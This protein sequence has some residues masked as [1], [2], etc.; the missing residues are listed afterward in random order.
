MVSRAP[1]YAQPV[2]SEARFWT[3]RMRWR[4]R[5]AWQWPAFALLTLADGI[6]LH[7]LPPIRTGVDLIPAWIIASFGNLLLVGL[8]APWIA[9]RLVSRARDQSTSDVSA[10]PEVIHDRTGTAILVAG[11]LALIVTGLATRPL[12]VSETEAT[13]RLAAS[14][15]DYVLAH[16]STE[17]RRNLDTA[18]TTQTDEQGYFRTCIALDDRTRAFCLFVDT[19][20]DP[21][22]IVEDQDQRPNQVYF[23]DP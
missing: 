5:G 17:V 20:E 12:V 9:R 18:N 1:G 14:V 22:T 21:P 11:A 15:R 23:R 10:P 16:G 8:V 7:L 13:E 4:L 19:K 6:I 3:R 2:T